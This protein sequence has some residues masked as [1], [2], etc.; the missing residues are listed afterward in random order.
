MKKASKTPALL[1]DLYE[2]TMTQA[3]FREGMKGEATFSLFVRREPEDRGYMVAAGMEDAADFLASFRFT[4]EEID[5]LGSL[6]RFSPDFLAH[7]ADLRF[8]GAA[9]AMREGRVCF[10]EEPLLEVTAPVIEAQLVETAVLNTLSLQTT[11]ATKAARCVEAARG[12]ALVDF[13]LRRAQG[14]D[15]G[16]QAAR[17][18]YLA[19][20]DATSNV[21]AGMEYGIPVSGTLA[22]SFIMCFEREEEGLRAFARSFP[23]GT[24]LLIDTYDTLAG[25][26]TAV[27][28]ADEL[29]RN[30]HRL[31]G[32]RLDSGDMAEQS[33]GVRRILDEAGHGEVKIFASGGFDE[34]KIGRVL[35]RGAPIDGFGVGTKWGVSA[36]APYLDSA[37]KLVEYG[38]RQVLK[39]SSSKR[40]L[41]SPKQVFRVAGEDGPAGDIIGLRGE[42]REHPA[43]LEP[44]VEEGRRLREP[45]PLEEARS[46]CTAEIASLPGECRRLR[47]PGEYPV[48]ISRPLRELQEET[49]ERVAKLQEKDMEA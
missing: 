46:A 48:R 7:L 15:A 10:P 11:L 4:A 21:A 3:Y 24:I 36:D 25:A 39:F 20:F 19:G 13:S 32:V 43:L 41:V 47:D 35:A 26:R 5:H 33:K 1:T 27:K 9:W 38:G 40:T 23:D 45:V 31:R 30:G 37:Y 44:L 28:I 17:T 2:L 8:S 14:E 18:G 34:Y 16:M 12:R 29:E 49:A 6:D 22:H 42:K